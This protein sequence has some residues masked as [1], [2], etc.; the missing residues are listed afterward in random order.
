[1]NNIII[2]LQIHWL[3]GAGTHY[4]GVVVSSS[5]VYYHSQVRT[6]IPFLM[7]TPLDSATK[8]HRYF[9]KALFQV[10]LDMT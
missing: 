3:T 10:L 7:T 1:M 2:L 9:L 4:T 6:C 8:I 5:L